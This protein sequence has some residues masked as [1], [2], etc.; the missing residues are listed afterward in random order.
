MLLC[1]VVLWDWWG[2]VVIR[3]DLACS[4]IYTYR[5]WIPSIIDVYILW[6]PD[7]V[8]SALLLFRQWPPVA[9]VISTAI[10][11][12]ILC[13]IVAVLLKTIRGCFVH[14]LS[15][16]LTGD[17]CHLLW[18]VVGVGRVCCIHSALTGFVCVWIGYFLSWET[19]LLSLLL[20]K[21]CLFVTI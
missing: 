1:V 16:Y 18:E 5:S 4:L 17:L 19:V 3:E 21:L 15:W 14:S 7:I 8:I 20:L 9:T 13:H 11:M 12:I 6:W 2:S 10:S